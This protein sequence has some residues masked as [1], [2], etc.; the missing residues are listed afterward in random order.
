CFR[1]LPTA[2][3]P[4]DL[5]DVFHKSCII[6]SNFCRQGL[7]RLTIKHYKPNQFKMQVLCKLH[8]NNVKYLAIKFW[9]KFHTV[10]G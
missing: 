8:K 9:T 4:T 3:V 1:A 6:L 5:Y 10:F 7:R 2:P